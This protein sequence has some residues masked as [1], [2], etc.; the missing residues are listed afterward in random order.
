[1]WVVGESP[2]SAVGL[3]DASWLTAT[4]RPR[5][6]SCHSIMLTGCSP[7]CSCAGW[8]LLLSPSRLGHTSMRTAAASLA[9]CFLSGRFGLVFVVVVAESGSP[10]LCWNGGP[11]VEPGFEP[12]LISSSVNCCV[13]QGIGERKMWLHL[14]RGVC[15]CFPDMQMLLK[16]HHFLAGGHFCHIKNGLLFS[17]FEFGK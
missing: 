2:P 11:G 4:L 7:G 10:A 14:T 8:G 16:K 15:L 5:W 13:P 17:S 9:V 1:M 3:N 12:G 6:W